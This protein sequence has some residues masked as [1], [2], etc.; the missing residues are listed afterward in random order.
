MG[1]TTRLPFFGQRLFFKD[2]RTPACTFTCRA[3]LARPRPRERRLRD[4]ASLPG[5]ITLARCGHPSGITHVNARSDV[6]R[7]LAIQRR[8]PAPPFF[9]RQQLQMKPLTYQKLQIRCRVCAGAAAL[10]TRPFRECTQRRRGALDDPPRSTHHPTLVGR[11]VPRGAAGE[12]PLLS[13][14]LTFLQPMRQYN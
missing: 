8:G 6:R 11:Y 3:K 9:L 7:D 5:H 4:K 2:E 10:N 13:A 12:M 14:S 1:T